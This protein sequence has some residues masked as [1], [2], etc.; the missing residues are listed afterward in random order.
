MPNGCERKEFLY[1]AK[2]VEYYRNNK[3]VDDYLNMLDYDSSSVIN[4]INER[5]D[6]LVKNMR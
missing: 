2:I 4:D 3:E 6:V 5:I 1:I